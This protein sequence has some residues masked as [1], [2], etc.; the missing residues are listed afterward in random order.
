VEWAI[1]PAPRIPIFIY[2]T[3]KHPVNISSYILPKKQINC[4]SIFQKQEYKK[5]PELH[6]LRLLI[7]SQLDIGQCVWYQPD[8]F[9]FFFPMGRKI[10]VSLGRALASGAHPRRI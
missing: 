1:P 7:A 3:S 2:P 5:Q 9:A 6:A 4:N 10:M 8:L